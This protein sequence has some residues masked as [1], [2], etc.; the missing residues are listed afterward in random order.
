V[1][2][3]VD[4][5]PTTDGP[6]A[7]SRDMRSRDDSSPDE[8]RH[9]LLAGA[10]GAVVASAGYLIYNRLEDE[11]KEALRRTVMKFVEEKVGDLRAQLKI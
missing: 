7:L 4:R 5:P 2:T 3:S 10:L 9:A 8:L 6:P 11:H 1:D